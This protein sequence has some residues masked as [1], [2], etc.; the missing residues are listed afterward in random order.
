MTMKSTNINNKMTMTSKLTDKLVGKLTIKQLNE[1]LEQMSLEE[2]IFYIESIKINYG[3]SIIK[4]ADKYN[5]KKE[6]QIK[7]MT[8]LEIMSAYEIEAYKQGA[9]Y[10]AGIDEAG[11]GPLAGPVV[12]ACVILPEGALIEK[13]NDSKKL[14]AKER[15]RLYEVIRKQAVSYGI[16]IVEPSY[17]DQFNILNATKK[18]MQIAIEVMKTQPDIL[19]IDAVKLDRVSI[20]QK[21]IIRGDSLSISIAAASILAKVTRDRMIE[22]MDAKYPEYG[23]SQHKGYGTKEHIEA[24]RKF[25]I[26][27][28]HRRTFTKNF[29]S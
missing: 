17:I 25:G 12:A 6:A 14:S 28:I 18:A 8:R 11:R 4:I 20:P 21:A 5:K 13:I 9:K 2:A 27:D 26:C 19:L 15:D 24:I 3:T 23:F 16:G 29:V 22:K 10:V 7:E 1:H